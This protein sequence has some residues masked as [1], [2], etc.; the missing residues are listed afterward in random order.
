MADVDVAVVHGR[1]K[2]LALAQSADIRSRVRR[3][4]VKILAGSARFTD[5]TKGMAE[6]V[7]IAVVPAIVNAIAHATGHRFRELPVTPDKVLA[8]L[9]PPKKRKSRRF[10][11]Q[12]VRMPRGTF[13][14]I[15]RSAVASP[16]Q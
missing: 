7:M 2:G 3:E 12:P 5:P 8:A 11:L 10:T 4:G 1:V 14:S 13:W 16:P 9:A 15:P 6:V